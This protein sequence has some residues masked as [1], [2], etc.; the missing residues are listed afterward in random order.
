M[1]LLRLPEYNCRARRDKTYREKSV[2]GSNSVPRV[3]VYR[4]AYYFTPPLTYGGM[5]LYI[6]G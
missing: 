6:L 2:W 1:F 5:E 4:R 3:K